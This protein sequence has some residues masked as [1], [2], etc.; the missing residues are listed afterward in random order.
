MKMN[1]TIKKGLFSVLAC[2][3]LVSF[4][5]CLGDRADFG[6][7]IGGM[8]NLHPTP[9]DLDGDGLSNDDETNIYHTDPNDPD[10][11][12]D[13]LSDGE[14]VIKYG[15]DPNN[16]DTD[17]DGL[18]D[19]KEIEIGT[20]PNDPDTDGDG[21]SDGDEVN[22][23][24]TD[25]LKQDTDGDGL[26][27][28]N[29]VLKYKTDPLKKDTDNDGV[30]DGR[31]VYNS[32]PK[33]PAF[34]EENGVT[35]ANTR[36]RDNPDVIDALDP[37]N[38]S[39]HDQRPNL[40]ETQKGTDPWDENSKYPWIYETPK[41]QAMEEAGYVYVPG[42]FDVDG[43][44]TV[45]K[46]FWMAKYEARAVTDEPVT[47][48]IDNFSAYVNNHFNVFAGDRAIGYTTGRPDSSG[49]PLTKVQFT[50][51]GISVAGMYGFEAETML[52]KSQV[53]GG[54]K[55][56][57]PS[58]KQYVQV[59]KL[60]HNNSISNDTLGYDEEVEGNYTRNIYEIESGK[61]EFTDTLLKLDDFISEDGETFA[62]PQWWNKNVIFNPERKAY[63]GSANSGVTGLNDDYAL[64][65]YGS[66]IDARYGIS[67]GDSSRI[68]FRA[69]SDYI[70]D[71]FAF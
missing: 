67:Y 55:I 30:N 10:S 29:E 5:G 63:A 60:L 2:T 25:P 43:D 27:D 23:Y 57:L 49:I 20:D 36:H 13:G 6:N 15:T 9:D 48:D 35:P 59:A 46:G 58:I 37:M 42:G 64:L 8:G 54:W 53:T 51:N 69:A 40:S 65:I 70:E 24:G 18:D 52:E 1:E 71:D 44:G 19:K 17:G 41:G 22:K 3:F 33:E 28:G 26:W 38:D 45:E 68:G 39:D 12:D 34:D 61:N 50:D 4:T 16:P 7:D 31:E 14:E 66:R 32:Y 21:L 56:H 62:K 11:D 47:V